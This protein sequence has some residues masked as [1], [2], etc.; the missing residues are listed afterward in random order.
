MPLPKTVEEAYKALTP[1]FATEPTKGVRNPQP[2]WSLGSPN[3]LSYFIFYVLKAEPRRGTKQLK[4]GIYSTNEESIHGLGS[5]FC[6]NLI[7]FRSKSRSLS[8]VKNVGSHLIKQ[9]DGSFKG[10]IFWSPMGYEG[11]ERV[12]AQAEKSI[13]INVDKRARKA[14]TVS[15]ETVCLGDL[16]PAT[17]EIL[18]QP[19]CDYFNISNSM[20][21]TLLKEYIDPN[22]PLDTLPDEIAN[23]EIPR[24]IWCGY[25]WDRAELNILAVISNDVVLQTA[26]HEADFHWFTAACTHP[27]TGAWALNLLKYSQLE[28]T[29]YPLVTCIQNISKTGASQLT[30][31]DREIAKITIFALIYAGFDVNVAARI[32]Q[33]KTTDRD[34]DALKA[35]C[36]ALK[37]TFHTLVNWTEQAAELW[38]KN[39]TQYSPSEYGNMT[40]ESNRGI[41]RYLGGGFRRI[42]APEYLKLD[43][44][45]QEVLR[46]DQARTAIN[47][48]AQNVVAYFLKQAIAFA[49]YDLEEELNLHGVV[50]QIIPLFD[51]VSFRADVTNLHTVVYT[52]DYYARQHHVI[53]KLDGQISKGKLT[54]KWKFSF[55]SWGNMQDFDIS[56]P[57]REPFTITHPAD[58][59]DPAHPNNILSLNLA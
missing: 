38:F 10:S 11:V 16:S 44:S 55:E 53:P 58:P 3:L 17:L 45:V 4:N 13:P 49:L 57:P 37:K 25:D 12:F 47:C 56:I 34:V 30:L 48:H 52:F 51:A 35:V 8:S 28:P 36:E 21:A 42:L 41:V 24:K 46:T 22:I 26:L 15:K 1:Q 50:D 54:P 29:K 59:T 40:S 27:L 18:Y 20:A 32:T 7:E 2:N 43:K 19:I 23:L 9:P 6:E 5:S 31:E 14:F 39:G 33:A